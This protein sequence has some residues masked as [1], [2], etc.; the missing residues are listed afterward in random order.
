MTNALVIVGS[1]AIVVVAAAW[2]SLPSFRFRPAGLTSGDRA[3]W[4]NRLFSLTA[5]S[6]DPAV[7]AAAKALIAA[8]VANETKKGK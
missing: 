7:T 5:T 2:P 3:A 8:L 6:D 4:V 1:L